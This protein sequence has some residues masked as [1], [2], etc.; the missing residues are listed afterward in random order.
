MCRC[1][2]NLF[3]NKSLLAAGLNPTPRPPRGKSRRTFMALAGAAAGATGL[4]FPAAWPSPTRAPRGRLQGGTSSLSAGATPVSARRQAG[5][6]VAVGAQS[7]PAS[8]RQHQV[9]DLAGRRS[10]RLSRHQ[11]SLH[12]AFEEPHRR[13]LHGL[14]QAD[15]LIAELKALDA[16]SGRRPAAR[17]QF[18]QPPPG[19]GPSMANSTASPGPHLHLVHQHA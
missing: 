1:V 11:H 13:R 10:S 8:G 9:I 6:I 15:R 7:S 18:R 12:G 16:S 4:G 3:T 14:P 19:R 5:K 17:L 2:G